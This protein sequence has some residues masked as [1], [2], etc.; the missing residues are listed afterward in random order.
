MKALKD[1]EGGEY[2]SVA[3]LYAWLLRIE[4]DIAAE[5]H[6]AP[7]GCAETRAYLYG[8]ICALRMLRKS[9][10]KLRSVPETLLDSDA[11]DPVVARHK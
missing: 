6:G 4:D 11:V 2:L 9:V 7:D 5:C 10:G 1:S 3:E 8:E